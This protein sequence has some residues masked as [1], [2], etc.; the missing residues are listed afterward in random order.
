MGGIHIFWHFA[1]WAMLYINY[2]FCLCIFWFYMTLE[3][4]IL[5]FTKVNIDIGTKI[6]KQKCFGRKTNFFNTYSN[7]RP[8]IDIL[9]S[10]RIRC[11]PQNT[12]NWNFENMKI[13]VSH[14]NHDYFSKPRCKN[15]CKKLGQKSKVSN[16]TLG[17]KFLW[18]SKSFTKPT[19]STRT[20]ISGRLSTSSG[21]GASDAD[22]KT[23]KTETLKT[24]KFWF[25]IPTMTIFLNQGA[26]IGAKS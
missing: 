7:F 10:R 14:P 16:T 4:H 6:L 23:P 3:R 2:R 1:M 5:F 8:A 18:K 9:R 19:F 13:L 17:P 12:K 26:K 24:W 25:R 15:R 21:Q 11:R 20:A 22:L